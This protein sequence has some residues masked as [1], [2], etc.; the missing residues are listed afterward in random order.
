MDLPTARTKALCASV[1]LSPPTRHL[2]PQYPAPTYNTSTLSCFTQSLEEVWMYAFGRFIF[3]I[4]IWTLGERGWSSTEKSFG[5]P[6]EGR[7]G[8][9]L[10]G[11]LGAKGLSRC[12]IFNNKLLDLERRFPTHPHTE[13]STQPPFPSCIG[14]NVSVSAS[15]SN[16]KL[17]PCV[18]LRHS[19][20][21]LFQTQVFGGFI[22][23]FGIEGSQTLV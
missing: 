11:S 22:F 5:T 10:R 16:G 8:E 20:S 21:S 4:I 15:H 23:T 7:L 19:Q 2:S 1:N 14:K 13:L 3:E 12:G 9:E 18:F 17:P 6:L